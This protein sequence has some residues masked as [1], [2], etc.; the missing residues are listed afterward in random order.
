MIRTV[1]QPIQE[2][3]ALGILRMVNFRLRTQAKVT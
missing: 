1:R 2:V 3:V